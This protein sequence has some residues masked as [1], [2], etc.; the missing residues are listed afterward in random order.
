MHNIVELLKA[1]RSCTNVVMSHCVMC[2][3][4]IGHQPCISGAVAAA[5]LAHAGFWE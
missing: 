1:G 2:V 3:H 4:R 5:G